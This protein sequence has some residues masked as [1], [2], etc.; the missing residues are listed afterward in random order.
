MESRKDCPCKLLPRSLSSFTAAEYGDVHSLLKI[1]NVARR[2]DDY[3]YT[4]LHYAAQFNHVAATALL[5]NLGCP[6]DGVADDDNYAI[7]CC[8][9][10]H[11]AAFSGATAS[12][13]V[14]LEWN[15]DEIDD[16]IRFEKADITTVATTESTT[17]LRQRLERKRCDLLAKDT[18]F[19]DQSTP[20]HKA[21][22]GGRYLSIYLLLKAM[23]E[24]ENHQM[25]LSSSFSLLQ[26]GLL[27]KDKF[28]RT[29]L[30]VAKYY[31]SI[32]DTERPAVSRWD[33]V[34]GGTADWNK[35][36]NILQNIM[37]PAGKTIGNCGFTRKGINVLR[38]EPQISQCI[39]INANGMNEETSILPRTPIQFMKRSYECL[40]CDPSNGGCRVTHWQSAFEKVLGISAATVYKKNSSSTSANTSRNYVHYSES[41]QRHDTGLSFRLNQEQ[42]YGRLKPNTEVG[43]AV[44]NEKADTTTKCPHCRQRC[45]A[46]YPLPGARKF[47]C[48]I[49]LRVTEK[50]RIEDTIK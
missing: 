7:G 5:L 18:S 8:T 23:K 42:Q 28:G 4:P 1:E 25:E 34:A 27:S 10:L 26:Y 12:M 49:C 41:S 44:S 46:F 9:P 43:A 30:D 31:L 17:I 15:K 2:R 38:K 13:R 20:L 21:A 45:V 19:G 39:V 29:P 40:D 47:V 6:V 50:K 33:A 37:H 32:Q 24:R 14:L 11:R 22:A 35:C 48:K 16:D 3:G 36:V